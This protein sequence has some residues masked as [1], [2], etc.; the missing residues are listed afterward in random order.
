MLAINFIM[1]P[2]KFSTFLA[3]T[4][5]SLTA[6]TDALRAASV[7]ITPSADT[8]LFQ[9]DPAN[10]FGSQPDFAAGTT[11]IA[12]RSRGLFTFN[13]AASV[14]AGATINSVSLTLTVVKVPRSGA[15][16]S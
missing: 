12:T 15:V 7:S 5:V 4:L 13:V 16:N 11:A 3:A 14:P 1:N 9:L 6:S 8:T 10:N 2:Q